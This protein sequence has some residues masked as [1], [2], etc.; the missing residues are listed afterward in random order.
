MKLDW[1]W[2]AA[3]GLPLRFWGSDLGLTAV[4]LHLSVAA[5]CA[6]VPSDASC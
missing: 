2:I 1:T 5:C 3:E 4:G 6:C